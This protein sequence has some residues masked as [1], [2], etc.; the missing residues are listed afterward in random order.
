MARRG[1]GC[2]TDQTK[3]RCSSSGSGDPHEDQSGTNV[4]HPPLS[5]VSVG[6]LRKSEVWASVK[7]PGFLRRV[8]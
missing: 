6:E 4:S 2:S 8:K 7:E 3:P 1:S 5:L